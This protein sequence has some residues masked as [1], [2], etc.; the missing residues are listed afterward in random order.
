VLLLV[1]LQMQR[2][3]EQKLQQRQRMGQSPRR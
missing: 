3:L 1:L 2:S